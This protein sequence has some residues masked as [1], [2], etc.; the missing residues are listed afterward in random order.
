MLLM[1]AEP[2][3]RDK[4]NILKTRPIGFYFSKKVYILF[5]HTIL[6]PFSSG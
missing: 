3:C 5:A 6:L 1:I 4:N 2:G